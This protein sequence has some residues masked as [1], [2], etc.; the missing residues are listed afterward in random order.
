[1]SV[2]SIGTEQSLIN[3]NS[4]PP[5][6]LPS[7]L[8]FSTGIMKQSDESSS[9]VEDTQLK[10]HQTIGQMMA[11]NNFGNIVSNYLIYFLYFN[12]FSQMQI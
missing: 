1:M 5:T 2:S 10:F 4:I 11:A 6:S 7:T 12:L 9:T 3:N 8:S